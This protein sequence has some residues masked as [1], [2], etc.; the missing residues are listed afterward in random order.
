MNQLI[1]KHFET[2]SIFDNISPL[3]NLMKPG[4]WL[5]VTNELGEALGI[6]SYNDIVTNVSKKVGE[7][8]FQKPAVDANGTIIEAFE[9]MAASHRSVLPVYEDGKFVGGITHNDIT[10]YLLVNT[11]QVYQSVIH[12]LRNSVSNLMGL[13]KLLEVNVEKPENLELV[14][15]TERTCSHALNILHELLFLERLQGEQ[16]NLEAIDL[17]SFIK[18]CI[19][20]MRGITSS[21]GISIFTQISNECFF[22]KIDPTHFKRA[23]HN[24]AM[25]AVKFSSDKGIICVSTFVSE[26]ACTIAIEDQGI[27]IPENLQPY[28]FD[29]FTQAGRN[30]NNG[31][32]STGIGLY[33]SKARIEQFNGKMWFESSE[34]SG[35]TFF[36]EFARA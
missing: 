5:V 27:G 14:T 28:I 34:G 9:I 7:C 32:L 20:E 11:K 15:L 10:R 21:K 29:Q 13:N 33:F 17:N 3:Y 2:V 4:A 31:E 8:N 1:I 16:F 18:E 25:N 36:I 12:D 19:E 6:L 22:H 24:L 35:T 30:G 23:L 26:E